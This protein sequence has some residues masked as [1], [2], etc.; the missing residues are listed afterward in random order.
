M[1]ERMHNNLP[2]ENLNYCVER[3]HRTQNLMANSVFHLDGSN[4]YE[5]S[6]WEKCV[7]LSCANRN[8]TIGNAI[9]KIGIFLI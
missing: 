3:K 2:K 7:S 6:K 9:E 1:L 4:P 5:V 8:G